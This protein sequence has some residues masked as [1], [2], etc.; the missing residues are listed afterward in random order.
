[1]CQFNTKASVQHK[2]LARRNTKVFKVIYYFDYLSF[3]FERMLLKVHDLPDSINLINLRILIFKSVIRIFF[4]Y[5]IYNSD[6]LMTERMNK[7]S[8]IKHAQIIKRAPKFHI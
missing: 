4:Y 6:K 7:K 8:R 5:H 1:M 3:N 2:T